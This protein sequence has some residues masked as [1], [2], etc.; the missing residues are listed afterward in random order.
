MWIN[1]QN[2]SVLFNHY[3][4]SICYMHHLKIMNSSINR[5]WK[6]DWFNHRTQSDIIR[7]FPPEFNGKQSLITT[8]RTLVNNCRSYSFYSQRRD[9]R[10]PGK[11][12]LLQ[13][14]FFLF[15]KAFNF[16]CFF[17]YQVQNLSTGTALSAVLPVV[18][19]WT[20]IL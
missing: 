15:S 7:H 20:C 6:S 18:S 16:T 19:Y 10:L 11:Y 3:P 9:F 2:I 1:K 14:F 13:M 12:I 8:A 17:L 5:K 4:W